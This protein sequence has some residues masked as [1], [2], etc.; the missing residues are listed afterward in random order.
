MVRPMS[1]HSGCGPPWL[2]L[3]GRLLLDEVFQDVGAARHL[4]CQRQGRAVA[5]MFH[6]GVAP[7]HQLQDLQAARLSTALALR[8]FTLVPCSSRWRAISWWPL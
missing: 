6:A 8:G 2:C 7:Q 5:I 3:L 4:G 1:A